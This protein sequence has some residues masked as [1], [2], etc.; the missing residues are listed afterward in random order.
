MIPESIV[1]SNLD[2]NTKYKGDINDEMFPASSSKDKKSSSLDKEVGKKISK[3][4][5]LD[6]EVGSEPADHSR[7]YRY[8]SGKSSRR[9]LT[10]KQAEKGLPTDGD[11]SHELDEQFEEMMN[12]QELMVNQTLFL[13]RMFLHM[14]QA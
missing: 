2:K 12:L 8:V 4:S 11:R 10:G 9:R 6:K 13:Y 14:S 1:Q 5:S 3:P 7:V